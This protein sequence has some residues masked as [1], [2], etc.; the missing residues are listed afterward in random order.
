MPETALESIR[1]RYAD[2]FILAGDK[3]E[4]ERLIEAVDNAVNTSIS[5]DV[6]VIAKFM[7]LTNAEK[8]IDSFADFYRRYIQPTVVNNLSEDLRWVLEKVRETATILWLEG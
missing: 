4:F 3:A 5:D 6:G 7:A 2:L 1:D 8:T